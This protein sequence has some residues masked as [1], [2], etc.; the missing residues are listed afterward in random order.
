MFPILQLCLANRPLGSCPSELVLI[1]TKIP[2]PH[3]TP[4]LIHPHPYTPAHTS[5]TPSPSC[6]QNYTPSH[7]TPPHTPSAPTPAH[8]SWTPS[9]SCSQN[10]T[11]SHPHTQTH[12]LTAPQHFN[13]FYKRKY[14]HTQ[15]HTYTK[16]QAF[17]HFFQM[18]ADGV[19]MLPP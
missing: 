7:H 16:R 19:R 2:P 14:I 4:L 1:H 12:K 6:S 15:E 11:P 3:T 17:G 8:T 13:H 5:W 18:P 10:H 9:P